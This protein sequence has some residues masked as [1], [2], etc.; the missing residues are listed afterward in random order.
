MK[1]IDEK[2]ATLTTFDPSLGR[3]VPDRVLIARHP[4]VEAV[5]EVWHYE[6]VKEYPNGGKDAVKVIDT[7]GVEAVEAWDEY[8]VVMR[9]ITYTAEELAEREANRKPTTAEQIAELQEALEMLLSGV[10]E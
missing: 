7:P 3:L 4:A 2:G 10:T 6:T 9:F 1:I 5:A 8:E